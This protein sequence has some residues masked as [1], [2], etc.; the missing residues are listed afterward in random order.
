LVEKDVMSPVKV[1]K[2]SAGSFILTIPK[3]EVAEPL[4][5]RGDEKATVLFDK[6]ARR[7]VYEVRN[8]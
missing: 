5:L 2:T 8:L 3:H 6:K 1:R 4:K 7:I